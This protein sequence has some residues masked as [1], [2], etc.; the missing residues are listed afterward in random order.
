M[1]DGACTKRE[2]QNMTTR[3]KAT[4]PIEVCLS[5]PDL[6]VTC[7]ILFFDGS[8]IAVGIDS[9]S[10]AAAQSEMTMWLMELG[11]RPVGRWNTERDSSRETAR[12]FRHPGRQVPAASFPVLRPSVP[13][14]PRQELDLGQPREPALPR[15]SRLRR[16]VARDVTAN[17]GPVLSQRAAEEELRAWASAYLSRNEVIRAA[18]AAGISVRRIEQVT[19]IPRTTIMRILGSPPSKRGQ[20]SARH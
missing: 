9:L 8:A 10:I 19:G 4:E 16:T 15:A 6:E 17:G 3:G 11:Y 7:R 5:Q 2:C 12:T 18:D 20:N 13:A 14:V 1:P